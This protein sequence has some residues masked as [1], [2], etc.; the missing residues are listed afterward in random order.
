M[1]R[2][3]RIAIVGGGVAGITTAYFLAKKYK[4]V[5]FDPKGVAEQCSYANGGQLSVCNAE[6][7]NSYDNIIKGIK[8]L[9]Q[10]DAP[11]AFRPDHWSWSKVKWIAG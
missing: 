2:K 3:K 7:W 4:V 5:L 6:V 1:V 10:P 11:L 8:W 9:T